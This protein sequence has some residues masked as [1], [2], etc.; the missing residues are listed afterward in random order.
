MAVVP[1]AT[2]ALFYFY[3][4]FVI[5]HFLRLSNRVPG[6]GALR[7]TLVLVAG[8]TI[9]LLMKKDEL[10]GR[11]SMD[12][13]RKLLHF[14]AWVVITL[15][16]V[17]WPGSVLRENFEEWIR[18]VVF[19]FFTALIVDSFD[20]LKL[21]V[22]VF[23]GTQIFRVLEPLFLHVT[24]GYWGSETYI[25]SGE[26]MDRLGG[27]PHDVVNPNGLGFIIVCTVP[28]V[29]Y[30]WLGNRKA[31][32]ISKLLALGVLLASLYALL[33]SASRSGFLALIVTVGLILL[34]S[35]RKALLLAIIGIVSVV[36]VANMTDLQRDRYRSLWSSDTRGGATAQGRVDGV[37]GELG[38]A[39][40]HPLFGHGLGT[41]GEAKFHRSGGYQV[42]HNLYTE[43][44]IETGIPGLLLYLGFISAAL[45]SVRQLRV[46]VAEATGVD[47]SQ[48]DYLVALS[49]AVQVWALMCLFISL[50]YYGVREWHWYLMGGICVAAARVAAQC[51]AAAAANTSPARPSNVPARKVAAR[52]R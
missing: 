13:T 31:G 41:S 20:R 49:D 18:V 15:P 19:F 44:I 33:L 12:A 46:G 5:T 11:L 32:L 42:A 34:K 52:F 9:A 22:A 50:A 43:L 30:L 25:G 45:R 51:T 28:F 29:Y 36:A 3:L 6:I 38:L 37:V 7:P 17:V 47:P 23:V 26:F 39:M 48:R 35:Q 2:N 21:F 8:L 16:F 4:F 27:G 14:A 24:T 10:A 1:L 40:K